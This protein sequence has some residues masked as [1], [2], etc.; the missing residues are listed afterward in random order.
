VGGS[1]L[2]WYR[3]SVPGWDVP[4]CPD[5]ASEV[6]GGTNGPAGLPSAI[7]E[8]VIEDVEVEDVS[9]HMACKPPL[10]R[11]RN[12]SSGG[13]VSRKA[14]KKAFNVLQNDVGLLA[15]RGVAAVWQADQMH[16][17]SEAAQGICLQIGG[18]FVV[19]T[20]QH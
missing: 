3:R 6:N 7:L 13:R 17:R 15:M 4:G 11:A 18:V 5:V 9:L 1:S 19:R 12:L 10:G 2:R 20:L 14:A 8:Q 16:L